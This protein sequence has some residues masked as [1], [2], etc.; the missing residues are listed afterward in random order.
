MNWG[1][2]ES[3]P[4]PRANEAAAGETPRPGPEA[5]E[6]IADHSQEP[7]LFERD[8]GGGG[9]AVGDRPGHGER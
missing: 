2:A 6:D 8:G 4:E 7:C 1:A 9:G 5:L 3:E